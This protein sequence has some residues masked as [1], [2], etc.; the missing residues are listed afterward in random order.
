[1][2]CDVVI[3][4]FIGPVFS[5]RLLQSPSPIEQKDSQLFFSLQAFLF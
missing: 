5:I 3:E 2:W 1:M 4:I